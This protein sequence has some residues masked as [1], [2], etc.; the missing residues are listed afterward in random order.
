[1][2]AEIALKVVGVEDHATAYAVEGHRPLPDQLADGEHGDAQDGC[3]LL[4]RQAARIASPVRR[5][6]YRAVPSKR[7][8]GLDASA[9]SGYTSI[10]YI[11][12]PMKKG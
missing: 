3:R 8:D 1:M 10:A 11:C 7:H 5:L 12:I 4:D 2:L 6:D 9:P